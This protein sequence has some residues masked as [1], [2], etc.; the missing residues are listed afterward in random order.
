MVSV[1]STM[2]ELG[3]AA[4]DFALPDGFGKVWTLDDVAGPH[5]TLVAFVCNHCPYVR[6]IAPSFGAFATDWIA[7]GIGVVAVNSNAAS[8]DDDSVEKMA[9][10]AQA[11]GWQ[12]PYVADLDQAVAR[13][14]RAACTPDFYL[15]DSGRR[16]VYRGRMDDSTPRNGQPITG[17]DLA[18]AIE[19][20][21]AGDPVS[22]HQQASIGC[23]IKWL[24]GNEPGWFS[25][26]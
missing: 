16:L 11:W 15:F 18:A 9:G 24:P 4:P 7:A 17:A 26:L 20:L 10:E 14:H 1:K 22:A 2:L 12:F 13:A 6:H 21:V 25:L 3:T 5:G 19:A 8:R 23:N